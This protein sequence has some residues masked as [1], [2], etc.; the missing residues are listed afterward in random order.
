MSE[1]FELF[2]KYYETYENEMDGAYM[3]NGRH[4]R[5]RNLVRK[6]HKN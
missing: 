5:Y 2:T 3:N 4:Y 1:I 6:V